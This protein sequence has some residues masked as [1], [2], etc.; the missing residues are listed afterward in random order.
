MPEVPEGERRTVEIQEMIP[1]PEFDNKGSE[2]GENFDLMVSG[3]VDS[4]R[5][6]CDISTID[7]KPTMMYTSRV[8]TFKV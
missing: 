6:E 3:T 2:S 8:Y 5:Y 4:A 1:E 7:F